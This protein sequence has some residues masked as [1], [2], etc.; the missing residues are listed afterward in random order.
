MLIPRLAAAL[1]A[2][3][4][5]A[6]TAQAEP[7][8]AA[9]PAA[10]KGLKPFLVRV[11][12]A[13]A[14]SFSRTPSFAWTPVRNAALYEFE[15]A[16]SDTFDEGSIVFSSNTLKTPAVAVTSSLPWL[17][18]KPY[19]LYA[20]VRAIAPD[21]STSQW[22]APYGLNMRWSEVPTQLAGPEYPGLVQWG[23]VDGASAYD[24]WFIE[25]NKII[26]TKTNVADERE[27]YTF[28]QQSPWPD[29]VHWR[30]RAVRKTY[31]ALPNFLPTVSYGPW[32]PV[33]TSTN[34]PFDSGPMQAT[35]AVSDSTSTATTPTAHA[36]T[37]GF[38]FS[39]NNSLEGKPGELYRVY[40]FS[41]SDCV[42][43]VFK[44]ALV[45][46]PAYAPRMTGPLNLPGLAAQLFFAPQAFLGDGTEGRT[47]MRDS[48]AIQT[49][50]SDKTAASPASGGDGG[51]GTLPDP[52]ATPPPAEATSPLPGTPK[53][54]GAPVGLWD[55]GWP[56]GRYYWTV[57]P[58]EPRLAAN[59]STFVAVRA[60]SG[61]SQIVVNDVLGFG[62]LST[63][64]IGDG[65]TQEL[66]TVTKI[67]GRVL[68]LSGPLQFFHEIGE[69]VF[70]PQSL[71]EYHELD[72]PQDA[73]AAGRVQAFG[74]TSEPAVTLSGAP[75]VTGLS[76]TGR[77]VQAVGSKPSFYGSPLVSWKPALG[78][79]EYQIQWSPSRYPWRPVDSV[80]KDRY[81]KL[82]YG[83]SALLDRQVVTSTGT[84]R[85][86]LP[87][88]TWWYRVRGLDFS[89]PGTA[90]AMSWSAPVMVR[91]AKPKFAI[92]KTKKT[93]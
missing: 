74:K 71:V 28:H 81:E 70:F 11:D 22:S 60:K 69:R 68:T 90:R 18:G 84:A 77:L 80:T 58:A 92:V 57:V 36:L 46:S 63:V 9:A 29:V 62:E 27:Y 30:V 14:H 12:E 50:E 93:R 40:I 23:P 20:H 37:P 73:C 88:G 19:A 78:A 2:T 33:Q 48:S 15:L 52:A 26:R 42:N 82:T 34:P 21:G 17:T 43:V 41:D 91:I 45:G 54:S 72:M 32:S 64:V 66:V 79:D 76:P 85:G 55:S 24:V 86:P 53:E 8:F 51:G 25:P 89:L 31:G 83:T 75:F 65:E 87:P 35:A 1:F 7:R 49:T 13:E 5:L 61:D 3:L 4:V 47:F 39:G 10:P 59:L 6:T 16:T 38:A 44:G 67:T 56:N